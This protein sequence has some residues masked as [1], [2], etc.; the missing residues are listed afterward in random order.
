MYKQISDQ[1]IVIITN[2]NQI[3]NYDFSY[4]NINELCEIHKDKVF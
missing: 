2:P 3:S 1:D 4:E